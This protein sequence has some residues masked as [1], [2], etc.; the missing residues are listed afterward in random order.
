MVV[1]SIE[2]YQD[3]AADDDDDDDKTDAGGYEFGSIEDLGAAL[4]AG[5]ELD[6]LLEEAGEDDLQAMKRDMFG[7]DLY[8]HKQ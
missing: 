6:D 3:N 2:C 4:E 7:E 8:Q 5:F 1:S